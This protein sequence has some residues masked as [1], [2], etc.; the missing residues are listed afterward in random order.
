MP[1]Y[2]S[3]ELIKEVRVRKRL[4]QIQLQER[5]FRSPEFLSTLSRVE[6]LH[7]QPKPETIEMFLEM[8]DMPVGHFFC[9]YLES[10]NPE[11]NL[12]RDKLLHLLDVAENSRPGS[13]L[14][15]EDTV[16]ELREMSD[17]LEA[18]LNMES[19]LNL[20]FTMSCRARLE[21][22]DSKG[23]SMDKISELV[24]HGIAVTYPEFDENLF[25]GEML[26]FEEVELLHTLALSYDEV[27]R[28]KEAINLL[29]RTLAGLL[30]LPAK[31]MEKEKK[32]PKVLATLAKMLTKDGKY[33]EA[34]KVIEPGITA[35]VK[36]KIGWPLADLAWSMAVCL[37]ETG[38][39]KKCRTYSIYA[40]YACVM[41][42]MWEKAEWVQ[43]NAKDIFGIEI[44][45]FPVEY[46]GITPPDEYTP[47]T[48][49]VAEPYKSA[50]IGD[51]LRRFRE[52]ASLKAVDVYKGLCSSGYYSKIEN[53]TAT[54]VNVMLLEA[55]F[56]RAGRDL[57]RYYDAFMPKEEFE[58]AELRA[59]IMGQFAI[60]KLN[61]TEGL[62]KEL[63][64]RKSPTDK[65]SE[66]AFKLIHVN[67]L[68][69]QK[70]GLDFLDA[71]N[72]IASNN[73][74]LYLE[75][76]KITI[77]D[78]GEKKIDT[79]RLTVLECNLLNGLAASYAFGGDKQRGIDIWKRIATSL[80]N[81]YADEPSMVRF[82]LTA[83][84]NFSNML[85]VAKQYDG[86]EPIL[87]EGYELSVRRGLPDMPSKFIGNMA[88]VLYEAGEKEKSAKLFAMSFYFHGLVGDT[89]NQNHVGNYVKEKLGIELEY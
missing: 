18:S 23:G 81:S 50:S 44:E 73:T 71:R 36:R 12:L 8:L 89:R 4:Q 13:G 17:R 10:Q 6:N 66:Q 55:L 31:S 46:I 68:P 2:L 86:V 49:S 30:K 52:L 37:N 70:S 62:M 15:S 19:A 45:S 43:K 72:N 41:Y 34:K 79:Y 51:L 42:R 76:I 67:Y 58:E 26:G 64:E 5:S 74:D 69:Y 65:L 48:I 53:G 7:Q 84:H 78:F 33:E 39:R 16:N 40:Y 61:E 22:L 20:Q 1:N 85:I 77:P 56:Q 75:A 35:V 83:M 60:R 11:L 25:Q 21:L 38:D 24:K 47:T 14:A 32:L 87:A 54:N 27:G 63:Y 59:E 82:R 57:G 88:L 3:G 9:P 28:T 29:D 80:K